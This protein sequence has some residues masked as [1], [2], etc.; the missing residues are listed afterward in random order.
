MGNV[1]SEGLEYIGKID[2]D[3]Y[4]YNGSGIIFAKIDKDGYINKIGEYEYF[5]K[6][7]EDGTIRDASLDVVGNIQADGYVYI[8]SKRICKVDSEYIRTITP[9]AWNYGHAGEYPNRKSE[10]ADASYSEKSFNW[11]F[12]VGTTIKLAIAAILWIAFIVTTI[13][14]VPFISYL[15][16]LPVLVILVFLVPIIISIFSGN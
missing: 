13:G 10:T 7:D 3:G 4:V 14:E 8:H 6:I 9:D 1:I 2:D 5:G 12:G 11:P 15:I 16:A